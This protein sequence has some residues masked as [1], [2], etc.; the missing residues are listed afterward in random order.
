MNKLRRRW[1]AIVAA[2][3]ERDQTMKL[4]LA[5]L[6]A[7]VLAASASAQDAAYTSDDETALQQCVEAVNDTNSA[8][9][10]DTAGQL[11][12]IGAATGLCQ[13]VPGGNSTQGMAECNRREQA[14]WDMTLNAHYGELQGT[15]EPDLLESLKLAQR[16]W[17]KYRDA[18]CQFA[19]DLWAEGT[20][21]LVVNSYC[22]M[23]TTA[24]R[25]IELGD[26][27]TER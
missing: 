16:A 21:S 4:L 26:A 25:A 18:K 15:L 12:C 2:P 11:D 7:I 27:L 3:P 6:F 17:I 24:T 10:T 9:N 1:V 13:S 8:E 23:E 19:Y 5:G 14:W 20:I 22:M